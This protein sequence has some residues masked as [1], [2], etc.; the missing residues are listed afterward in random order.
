MNISRIDFLGCAMGTLQA[1]LHC[2]PRTAM[3]TVVWRTDT[4]ISN[5]MSDMQ[6][7]VYITQLVEKTRQLQSHVTPSELKEWLR[8]TIPN[9]FPP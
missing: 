8:V 2:D 4:E 3:L 7:S 9:K 1:D 5:N 6:V